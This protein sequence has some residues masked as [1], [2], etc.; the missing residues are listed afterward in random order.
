MSATHLSTRKRS[1]LYSIVSDSDRLRK[2]RYYVLRDRMMGYFVDDIAER[3]TLH[4][5]GDG[6][7]V[8]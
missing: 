2:S 7:Q 3:L 6:W 4:Q 8:R 1:F 5:E